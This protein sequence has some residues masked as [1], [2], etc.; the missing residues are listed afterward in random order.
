MRKSHR[1]WIAWG[2][3]SVLVVLCALLAWLQFRWIGEITEAERN[4]LHEQLHARLMAVS[5]AFDQELADACRA[6]AEGADATAPARR[7][8]RRS[9]VAWEENGKLRLALRDAG[10]GMLATAEWPAEWNG[11]RESL[12]ERKRRGDG[13]GRPPALDPR[14]VVLPRL[15]RP[16]EARGG[17][18]GGWV[19]LEPDTEYLRGTVVPQLVQRYLAVDGRLEYQAAVIENGA[20]A[21]FAADDSVA[22]FDVRPGGMRGPG[23][24]G[25]GG[26]PGGP[27][28]PDAIHGRWR[29]A[30]RHSAGSL[31]ALVAGTRRRNL[32]VSAGILLLMLATGA[33]LARTTRRAHQLAQQQLDFV[34]G[35]S[36]ELRTP[37]TVIRTAAYNL[38]GKLAQRPGQVESYGAMIQAESEKLQALV[39]QV[40][41]FASI[42]S[43]HIV[44]VRQPIAI[45]ALVGAELRFESG[46]AGQE[47]R[48][49]KEIE[50]GLPPV[51]GDGVAMRQAVQNLVDNAI[52]YGGGEHGWIGVRAC[53][54]WTER[55][56]AVEIR[57]ADRGPGIPPEEQR[58]VFEPFFRGRRAVADQIHGSGLG[59]S[60]TKK[61]VEAHGGEIRVRS[62]PGGGTEFMV[63]IPAAPAE[64]INEPA[65]SVG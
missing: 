41:R 24:R 62:E 61:I 12:A 18:E 15:A 23:P 34:A 5:R 31:E 29:L 7:W 60:L 53:T 20:P 10:T 44:R 16:G 19:L 35:V 37:L 46:V 2:A 54:V 28:P 33:V 59:L 64:L 39:E 45:D 55:G 63:R 9:G 30:V 57:V 14:L 17:P 49:E 4:R 40:L 56:T 13:P 1:A 21:P 65:Y 47:L 51:L 42:E 22:L 25:L 52:K 36:H 27:P 26:P 8:F 32:G 38:R 50:P 11:T 6:A 3:G 58:H 43:G 48:V